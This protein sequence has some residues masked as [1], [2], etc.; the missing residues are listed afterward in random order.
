M[1]IY[2]W[3]LFG[4]SLVCLGYTIGNLGNDKTTHYG[5]VALL[6]SSGMVALTWYAVQ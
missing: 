2:G 5:G 1:N 6:V 3:I 4:Y